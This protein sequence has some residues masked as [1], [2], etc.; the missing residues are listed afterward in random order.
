MTKTVKTSKVRTAHV[1]V[2]SAVANSA[3]KAILKPAPSAAIKPAAHV[4][5]ALLDRVSSLLEKLRPSE[6]AVARFVLRHPNLVIDLSFPDLA[7]K[8]GVSQP[9]IARFCRA[10]GFSGYRDFKL[11][12]A[13]SLANGVPFVH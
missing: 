5:S 13:Q 8:A 12:L 3:A 6:Q 1:A 10:A 4:P 7:E 9:T 2:T 11:R